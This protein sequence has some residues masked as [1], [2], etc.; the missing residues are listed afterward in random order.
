MD[1]H[2]PVGLGKTLTSEDGKLAKALTDGLDAVV[3]HAEPSSLYRGSIH[4]TLAGNPRDLAKAA[5]RASSLGGV[6]D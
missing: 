3:L 5:E 6:V 1:L 2:V 4:F